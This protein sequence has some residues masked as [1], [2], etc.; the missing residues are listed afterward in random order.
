MKDRFENAL[1]Q[2]FLKYLTLSIDVFEGPFEK[3]FMLKRSG[4]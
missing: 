1:Q 3:Y 4:F 2:G